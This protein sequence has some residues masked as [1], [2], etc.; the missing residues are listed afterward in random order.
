MSE[1]SFYSCSD[2]TERLTDTDPN[3][4]IEMFLDGIPRA[5]WPE[6]LQVYGWKRVPVVVS[7]FTCE[8]ALDRLLED[9]DEEYG[10]PDGGSTDP[11]PAMVAAARVFADAV[12]AEYVK[13][14]WPHEIDTTFKLEVN[15]LEWVRE[16]APGWLK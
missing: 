2:D 15:V 8:R 1:P 5:G 14:S 16:H 7:G 10:D 9:L 6:T 3:E 13:T 11:T 12:G 4:A